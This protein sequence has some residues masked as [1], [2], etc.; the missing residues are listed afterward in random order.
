[1]LP[2]AWSI[3]SDQF[4]CICGLLLCSQPNT[5]ATFLDHFLFLESNNWK[6]QYFYLIFQQ[7]YHLIHKC[8]PICMLFML[9]LRSFL[10]SFWGQ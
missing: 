6:R 8:G 3:R 2:T 10:L 7:I 5:L 9:L 4:Y 1:M